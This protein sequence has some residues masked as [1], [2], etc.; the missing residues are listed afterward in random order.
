MFPSDQRLRF[1]SPSFRR[2]LLITAPADSAADSPDSATDSAADSAAESVSQSAVGDAGISMIF[3]PSL[4]V[5]QT[6][7]DG[8]HTLLLLPMVGWPPLRC[9]RKQSISI[10]A[11]PAAAVHS[12]SSRPSSYGGHPDPHSQGGYRSYGGSSSSSRSSQY[13]PFVNL[14]ANAGRHGGSVKAQL[15]VPSSSSSSPSPSS[16]PPSSGNQ[17]DGELKQSPS[18]AQPG[19]TEPLP[20]DKKEPALDNPGFEIPFYFYLLASSIVAIA[21]V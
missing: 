5:N 15:S 4:P 1:W 10:S 2:N 6:M 3:P 21:A 11:F 19:S 12:S 14:E 9:S 17:K 8:V 20:W 7:S 13:G 16:S 18:W